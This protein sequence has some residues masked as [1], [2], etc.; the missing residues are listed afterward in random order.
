LVAIEAK[1]VRGIPVVS[2]EGEFEAGDTEV[3]RRYIFDLA[4]QL[5]DNRLIID[6]AK[7]NTAS[8]GA[9]RVM[10]L[11]Q[12]K[13]Q[14]LDGSLM[15]TGAKGRVREMMRLSEVDSLLDLECCAKSAASR[16]AI[17]TV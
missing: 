8:S 1:D 6:L 4:D 10:V 14:M 2:L 13:L 17:P 15:V 9:F 7:L 5:A 16:M 3:F 12:R 11:V